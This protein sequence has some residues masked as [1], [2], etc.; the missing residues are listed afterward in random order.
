MRC[1]YFVD[2]RHTWTKVTYGENRRVATAK[3]NINIML[4]TTQNIQACV[5]IS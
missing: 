5:R 2:R 4:L 3:L 1:C